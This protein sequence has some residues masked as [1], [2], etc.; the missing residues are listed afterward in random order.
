MP[1]E[2]FEPPSDEYEKGYMAYVD[3]SGANTNEFETEAFEDWRGGWN[4]ACADDD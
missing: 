1:F 2:K 4:D 3:G